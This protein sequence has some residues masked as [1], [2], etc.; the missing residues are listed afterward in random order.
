M[1]NS[2]LNSREVWFLYIKLAICHPVLAN[3]VCLEN[4]WCWMPRIQCLPESET[5][6]TALCTCSSDILHTRLASL[7]LFQVKETDDHKA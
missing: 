4:M 1:Y 6:P 5:R 2:D 7:S 3:E